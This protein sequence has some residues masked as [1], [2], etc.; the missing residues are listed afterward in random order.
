MPRPRS[1]RASG[2]ALR[3]A[4]G[5]R[6]LIGFDSRLLSIVTV[7]SIVAGFVQAFLLLVIARAA[8]GLTGDPSFATGSFGPFGELAASTGELLW[9]GAA[10][11]LVLVVVEITISWSQA[12]L[13]AT[14]QRK[15]RIHL[16]ETYGRAGYDAQRL[17][18]RGDQQHILNS[19]TSEASTVTAQLGNG[20]VAIANFTT[21]AV[22]A[23]VLSP[24]AAITVT[25][26]L[27]VMLAILR[28]ILGMG[29][30]SGD[31]HM[32]A[33]RSL[34]ASVVER[35]E[36]TLEVKSFGADDQATDAVAEQIG[37]VAA[38]TQRLRFVNRMS[39]VVYRIGAMALVL[40]MLAVITNVG[41][42]DFAVL[43]AALLMLLRSLSYGQAAQAAYQAINEVLPVVN[44]LLDE[45]RRLLDSS[46]TPQDPIEP[47][48]FGP[49]V[50][51]EVGFAYDDADDAALT[52]VSLTIEPGDF[53]AI[54]GASGSGKSTLMSLLLRLRRPTTGSITLDGHDLHRVDEAWWHRHV[55]YVPQVSKL[56]SGTVAEAIR[57][58]R[59]WISDDDVRRAAG[60]AHIAEEIEL[61]ADGYDTQV[62]QLGDQLS[63]GQR[64]RVALARARAGRPT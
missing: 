60:L 11:V 30:R 9:I 64:Q 12:A 19:L 44:Q 57:F 51:D 54:V 22:S 36:T 24:L 41:S 46:P 14:A 15:V 53:V 34:S 62:G 17:H 52:D 7:F 37:V 29:R 2:A 40:G 61:W 49:L 39:S 33:A 16:L 8:A 35:L 47:A 50:V 4:L 48:R 59:T 13:Q 25:G 58:G 18:Q 27:M 43:T 3:T 1:V 55:A 42:T 63:G 45:E 28:P 38:R 5:N 32:R 56:Q 23:F 10:L 20:M 21:L 6:R 31:A 26:G